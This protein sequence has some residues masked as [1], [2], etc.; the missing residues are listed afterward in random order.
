M[1]VL[2]ESSLSCVIISA[3]ITGNKIV[4]SSSLSVLL[5]IIEAGSIL[6]QFFT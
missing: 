3:G 4:G 5:V 2:Q 6:F 1:V